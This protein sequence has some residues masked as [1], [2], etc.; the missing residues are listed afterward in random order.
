MHLEFKKFLGMPWKMLQILT[1]LTQDDLSLWN[2]GAVRLEL[3]FPY[4]NQYLMLWYLGGWLGAGWVAAQ[5]I[6]RRQLPD[7]LKLSI[8]Q[9][10]ENRLF[11]QARTATHFKNA[12]I[13]CINM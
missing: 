11:S 9:N 3:K 4:L 6:L 5:K 13:W 2:E 12:K 8:A 7:S 10:I 1:A